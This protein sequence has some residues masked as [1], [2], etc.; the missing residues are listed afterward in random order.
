MHITSLS[1]IRDFKLRWLSL[2]LIRRKNMNTN[3]P[4]ELNVSSIEEKPEKV[5]P[6]YP[7]KLMKAEHMLPA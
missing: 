3:K 5:K 2:K 6:F 7:D 4:I 1:G